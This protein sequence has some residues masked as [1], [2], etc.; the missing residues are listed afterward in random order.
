MKTRVKFVLALFAWGALAGSLLAAER[1]E[2]SIPT[3]TADAEYVFGEA[4]DPQ[5][6]LGASREEVLA[7]IGQPAVRINA[8]A[9]AYLN[10]SVEKPSSGGM[11]GRDTL[12]VAFRNGK[13]SGLYL[14]KRPVLDGIVA[15]ARR[16][17]QGFNLDERL[18]AKP[19]R[20]AP[21]V[22]LADDPR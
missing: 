22:R 16:H 15:D 7:K 14:T 10:V 13:V 20:R 18:F 9:W 21:G 17:P 19:G 5:L 3:V 4:A 11:H 8:D 12:I 6:S 2:L 1:T